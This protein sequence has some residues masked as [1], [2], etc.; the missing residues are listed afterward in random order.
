MNGQMPTAGADHRMVEIMNNRMA[1]SM[2]LERRFSQHEGQAEQSNSDNDEVFDENLPEDKEESN[3][4]VLR[5]DQGSHATNPTTENF[6]GAISSAYHHSINNS[7]VDSR[8]K[9]N[10]ENSENDLTCNPRRERFNINTDE[11]EKLESTSKDTAL[12]LSRPSSNS[13]SSTSEVKNHLLVSSPSLSST[14]TPLTTPN[15]SLNALASLA[16]NQR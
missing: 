5:N 16:S 3:H 12:D 9:D 10:K 8:A 1:P 13:S 15:N 6:S 7:V 4:E 14:Q 11:E 2:S